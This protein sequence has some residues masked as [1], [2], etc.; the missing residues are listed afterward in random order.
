[1][2]A[3]CSEIAAPS[4]SSPSIQARQIRSA[5]TRSSRTSCPMASNARVTAPSR[6]ALA[7]RD[8]SPGTGRCRR[9][10]RDPM[11]A[12]RYIFLAASIAAVDAT[13]DAAQL[14]DDP[15]ART[16]D[17]LV[18]ATRRMADLQVCV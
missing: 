3:V 7:H 5:S 9:R 12:E 18:A 8:R 2:L 1:M 14:T 6:T 17:R 13:L 4:M 10:G 15:S 11:R 16:D